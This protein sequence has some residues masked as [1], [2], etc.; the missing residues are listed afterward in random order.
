ML[1]EQ[2]FGRA[3]FQRCPAGLYRDDRVRQEAVRS[4]KAVLPARRVALHFTG[5]PEKYL[6]PTKSTDAVSAGTT[7]HRSSGTASRAFM[8]MTEVPSMK[9]HV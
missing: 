2:S 3:T 1:G 6:L 7:R 8:V 9:V 4:I 5:H